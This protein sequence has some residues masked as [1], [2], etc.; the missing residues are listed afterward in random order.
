MK[1]FDEGIEVLGE[2][3]EYGKPLEPDE[4]VQLLLELPIRFTTG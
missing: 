3:L 2:P 4:R 1:L